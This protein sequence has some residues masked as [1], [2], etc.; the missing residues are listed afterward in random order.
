MK[1]NEF[2]QMLYTEIV[3]RDRVFMF[4]QEI[5]KTGDLHRFV[6]CE[7]NSEFKNRK[8]KTRGFT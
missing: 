7:F 2:I 3:H 8:F 6:N 1:K 5:Q 4:E